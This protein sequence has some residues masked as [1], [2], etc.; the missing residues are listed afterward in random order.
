MRLCRFRYQGQVMAGFFEDDYVVPL[1]LA[2]QQYGE[3]THEQLLLPAGDD[4]L[5]LLPHGGAQDATAKLA[6]WV[7]RQGNGLA[8]KARVAIE[9]LSCSFRSHDPINCFCWRAITPN[10]LK[11]GAVWRPSGLR[12]FLTCS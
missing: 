2:A 8:A 4:L 12:P 6:G 7:Q 10:I 9:R 5:A 11:K 1:S 3:T